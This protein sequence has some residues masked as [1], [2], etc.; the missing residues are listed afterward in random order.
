M[1]EWRRINRSCMRG[2]H[3]VS[4]VHVRTYVFKYEVRSTGASLNQCRTRTCIIIIQ[5]DQSVR[6]VWIDLIQSPVHGYRIG[7]SFHQS[8]KYELGPSSHACIWDMQFIYS[9]VS[10]WTWSS[11]SCMHAY[12]FHSMWII[13]VQYNTIQYNNTLLILKKEILL[14]AFHK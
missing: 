10:V 2:V 1:R 9:F 12:A 14:S 8:Y 3:P 13:E 7:R 5:F 4:G 6:Q 11:R